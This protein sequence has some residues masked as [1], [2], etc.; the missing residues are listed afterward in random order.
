VGVSILSTAASG[1]MRV[2][3]TLPRSSRKVMS[4]AISRGEA[5][6]DPE[7]RMRKWKYG[8]SVRPSSR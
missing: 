8:C 6:S 2:S 5:L 3:P 1:T 7:G 4:A